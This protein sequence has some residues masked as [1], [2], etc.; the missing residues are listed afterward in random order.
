MIKE[1]K[2]NTA[3]VSVYR[4][5]FNKRMRIDDYSG[6]L[7]EVIKIIQS[8]IDVWVEKVIV[9][10]RSE[11]LPFFLAQGFACEG[12]IKDYFSGADM[13]FVVKYFSQ[14]R[15]FSSRWYEEQLMVEK[16][17]ATE[18]DTKKQL[19]ADVQIAT[20]HE[21]E[22]LAELYK[23]VFTIYPTPL[24]N[25][26]YISKTIEEGTIYVFTQEDGEIVSAASAEINS[27]Y[28]NAELTDCATLA[29][30][31]GKGHIKKLLFKL[32]EKLFEK[33][34]TCLYSIARAQ[35][36][37]MNKAFFQLGYT[38]GGRLINNCFISSGIEDMNVWYKTV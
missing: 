18:I 38:Y 23:L 3:F 12:F 21:A 29:Q 35:S 15:G 28:K 22:E 37:G 14:E 1:I 30:A 32:E 7:F 27:K 31:Q 33:G 24:N 25:A 11:D 5:A 13:F 26:A 19:P 8:E 17:Q 2:N 34:F 6:N 16:I 9:K 10:S 4:D 20:I 36:F